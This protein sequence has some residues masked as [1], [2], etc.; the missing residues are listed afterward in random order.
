MPL[1]ASIDRVCSVSKL[2]GSITLTRLASREEI[3]T[4]SPWLNSMWSTALPGP[5]CEPPVGWPCR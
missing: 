2:L 4:I 5:R 1:G 3:Q